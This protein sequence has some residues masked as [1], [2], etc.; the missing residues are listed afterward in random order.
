[1]RTRFIGI[2]AVLAMLM[3]A[4]AAPVAASHTID[5]DD[6]T[7][8]QGFDNPCGTNAA[9]KLDE[10]W[11]EAGEHTY[12]FDGIDLTLVLDA[13]FD[14]DELDSVEVVSVSGGAAASIYV[15]A[16]EGTTLQLVSGLVIDPEKGISFILFCVGPQTPTLALDKV[17][18]GGGDA[19]FTF[20][21]NNVELAEP[22]SGEDDP[23]LIASA[24]GSY[25]IVEN[26]TAGWSL[27]G[28]VCTD[29]ATSA[30][31]AVTSVTNG[32]TVTVGADQDVTCTFTNAR[33]VTSVLTPTLTLDKVTVGGDSGF[34]FT[35]GG[36][37]LPALTGAGPSMQLATTAGTYVIAE[38]LTAQQ[39]AA[40]WSL[41]T[42]SCTGNAVAETVTGSSVSVVV[43]ADEDVICV[44]T[45]TRT[46][47]GTLPGNPVTPQ[48]P[49]T[50]QTPVVRGDTLAGGGLP[51][52]AMN[53]S[54]AGQ[55]P[56]VLVAV[57]T[58][59]S[60]AYVGRRNLIAIKSR[61]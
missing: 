53:S 34:V 44:F 23:R 29:N 36:A 40:G 1:M 54:A 19:G 49:V 4:L 31:L 41:T 6:F 5:V 7:L 57:L 55:I 48:A 61:R 32:V 10:S 56:A 59:A 9:V 13:T 11:I 8:G 38:A 39:I 21:L 51:N 14:E 28:I 16:G 25:T 47:G 20:T 50:P 22:L 46:G 33:I 37:A 17:V 18:T 12:T 2:L 58:L 27:S 52:T 15:H 26:I 45:N 42:I 35:L 43:G 24:G 30:E 60:L 3:L